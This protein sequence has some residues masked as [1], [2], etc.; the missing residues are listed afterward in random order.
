MWTI[1]MW[2]TLFRI[3]RRKTQIPRQTTY[4]S[5]VELHVEFRGKFVYSSCSRIST[6]SAACRTPVSPIK[7]STISSVIGGTRY[8][9]MVDYHRFLPHMIFYVKISLDL[10]WIERR[11]RMYRSHFESSLFEQFSA[12]LRESTIRSGLNPQCSSHCGQL[13]VLITDGRQFNFRPFY[14]PPSHTQIG[15]TCPKLRFSWLLR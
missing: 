13:Q 8:R 1:L 5:V 9:H 7:R 11:L 2:R 15:Q 6:A 4:L 12:F 14:W 3:W 10:Q